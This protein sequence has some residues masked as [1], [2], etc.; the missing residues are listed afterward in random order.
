[1][2]RIAIRGT[3]LLSRFRHPTTPPSHGRHIRGDVIT[4]YPEW[5]DPPHPNAADHGTNS[6]TRYRAR[7]RWS[8]RTLCAPLH[9]GPPPRVCRGF[10]PPCSRGMAIDHANF[11]VRCSVTQGLPCHLDRFTAV[12]AT[13]SRTGS[14]LWLTLPCDG[15]PVVEFAS[16][17]TTP[18]HEVAFAGGQHSPLPC[19]RPPDRQ[20]VGHRHL[21]RRMVRQHRV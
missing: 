3:V 12:I 18:S 17:T 14:V 10:T 13:W 2:I 21:Q 20:G 1:M 7:H 6:G 9:L 8:H 5:R 4:R 16:P 11:R 19:R 15:L